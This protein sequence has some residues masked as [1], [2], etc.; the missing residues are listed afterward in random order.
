MVTKGLS[1]ALKKALSTAAGAGGDFLPVPLATEFIRYVFNQNFLRQAFRVAPMISKTRDY[2]K[3]L[4]GT[5]VYYESTEGGTA[6]ETSMTTGTIRLTAK[7][8]MSQIT[9]SLKVFLY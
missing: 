6:T 9:I 8:F 7:K 3:V 4:G 1:D 5:K 2:P